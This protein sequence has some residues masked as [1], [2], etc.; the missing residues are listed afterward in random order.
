MN[1][2][3]RRK[4]APALAKE[5]RMPFIAANGLIVL[6][7]A[8]FYLQGKAAYGEFDMMFYAGQVLELVA[9]ATNLTLMG[10]NIRDG[11][12]RARRRMQAKG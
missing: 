1:L 11:R 9:G 10:L 8:T 6:L 7:L 3:R 12:A 5:K 4:D 2:G